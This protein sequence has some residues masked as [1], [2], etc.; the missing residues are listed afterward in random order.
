M[1]NKLIESD[2]EKEHLVY[3][4]E[5]IKSYGLGADCVSGNEV[6]LAAKAGFSPDKI[7]YAGV[8]KSDK[9]ILEALKVGIFSF[10][11]E[12][13]PEIQVIN[14]FAAKMGKVAKIALRINPDIQAAFRGQLR[15][16]ALRKRFHTIR[17]VCAHKPGVRI[18]FQ[19]FNGLFLLAGM[20]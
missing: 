2:F 11:C 15:L 20:E 7:V 16:I 8:G 13:I 1:G 3:I 9:E 18:S 17:D 4:L 6:K 10:N 5:I 12:S 14:N 19:Q